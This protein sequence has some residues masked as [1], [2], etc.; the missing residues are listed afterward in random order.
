MKKLMFGAIAGVGLLTA[1]AFT[2]DQRNEL[3]AQHAVSNPAINP[4]LNPAIVGSE[5]IVVPTALPDGKAQMLTVIDP[6]QQA[7]SV[8]RIDLSSGK[9]ALQSVRN[10]RWDLQMSHFNNEPPLPVDIHSSLEQLL[11]QK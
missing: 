8:Y 10:F 9:I 6:R 5:L 4:L 3:F 2:L 7:L 1:A 11:Q